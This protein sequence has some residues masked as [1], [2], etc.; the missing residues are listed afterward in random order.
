MASGTSQLSGPSLKIADGRS[1]AVATISSGASLSQPPTQGATTTSLTDCVKPP[2]TTSDTPGSQPLALQSRMP[3]PSVDPDSASTSPPLSRTAAASGTIPAGGR[4][5]EPCSRRLC[6]VGACGSGA[7][8]PATAVAAA[9]RRG[10]GSSTRGGGEEG[11]VGG[12]EGPRGGVPSG[13]EEG[14][15]S[16][17]RSASFESRR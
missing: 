15:V 11:A 4:L 10:G 2:P 7:V 16:R 3:P 5:P 6:S 1:M 9:S 13:R 14:G 17:T 8:V 12:V